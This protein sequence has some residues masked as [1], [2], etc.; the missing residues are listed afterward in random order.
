MPDVGEPWVINRLEGPAD[1]RSRR[2]LFFACVQVANIQ[3]NL[4]QNRTA[5]ADTRGVL[6]AVLFSP[7]EPLNLQINFPRKAL[8]FPGPPFLPIATCKRLSDKLKLFFRSSCTPLEKCTAVHFSCYLWAEYARE[9]N[10]A[11]ASRHATQKSAVLM[12]RSSYR[13]IFHRANYSRVHIE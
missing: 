7:Q 3:R 9:T 6:A 4:W 2:V 11:Y 5:S 13:S 8:S 1:L 10:E 12:S